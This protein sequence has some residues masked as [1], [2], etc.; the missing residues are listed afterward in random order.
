M[1]SFFGVM[2]LLRNSLLFFML[3]PFGLR[4]RVCCLL[5]RRLLGSSFGCCFG[6]SHFFFVLP[7]FGLGRLPCRF[8]L[9]SLFFLSLMQCL[10]LCCDP[11]RLLLSLLLCFRLQRSLRCLLLSLPRGLFRG[12]GCLL[13]C[14]LCSSIRGSDLRCFCFG[15]LLRCFLR[16]GLLLR[17]FPLG[18][19]GSR[20]LLRGLLGSSFGFRLRLRCLFGCFLLG[21]LLGFSLSSSLRSSLLLGSFFLSLLFCLCLCGSLLLSRFLGCGLRGGP[22]RGELLSCCFRTPPS[23]LSGRHQFLF[24]L[25]PLFVSGLILCKISSDLP[26]RLSCILQHFCVVSGRRWARHVFS[27]RVRLVVTAHHLAHQFVDIILQTVNVL[28]GFAHRVRLLLVAA[29]AVFSRRRGARLWRCVTILAGLL[30]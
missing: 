29:L 26:K 7:V 4:R 8:L 20:L 3:H 15:C 27:M 28:I 22:P 23:F 30:D 2:S 5:L 11:G 19:L 6:R 9:C 25:G 18:L 21:L 12:L 24:S 17:R 1:H 14:F 16:S 10:F 13:R